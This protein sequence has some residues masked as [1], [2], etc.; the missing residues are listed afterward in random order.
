M[1]A[2]VAGLVMIAVAVAAA[3]AVLPRLVENHILAALAD[4]GVRH[5]ELTVETVGWRE[6]SITDIRI[7]DGLTIAE[8]TALYSPGDVIDGRLRELIVAGLTLRG[9]VSGDGVT[10]A[11]LDPFIGDGDD[12]TVIPLDQIVLRESQIE[13]TTSLGD[14]TT[15]IAGIIHIIGDRDLDGLLQITVAADP[16][17]LTGQLTVAVSE[18]EGYNAQLEISEVT[19]G[20]GPA[21]A[22][23]VAATFKDDRLAGDRLLARR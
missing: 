18:T 21:M 14:I 16:A 7:G 19:L 15:A 12:D 9:A 1:K 6:A 2:L 20:A 10:F 5:A 13:L 23:E 17:G 22:G 3:L 8:V 11:G 4:A